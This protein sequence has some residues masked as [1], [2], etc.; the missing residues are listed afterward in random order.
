MPPLATRT[1][2]DGPLLVL[3]HGFTQTS[4][5]WGPF[6]T[7]LGR[8]RT[9]MAVDL[10]GHGRSAH[11]SADLEQTADLVLETVGDRHFDLLG[12]SLG[13]RVAVTTA[14]AAPTRVARLVLIGATAGIEDPAAAAERRARDQSLAD[15]IVAESNVPAFLERWLD[16]DLFADLSAEDAQRP[17]RLTNTAAGLADSLRRAG[18]G[19]QVSAW[20]RL[21]E[22]TM[23]TLVLAGHADQKFAD[24]GRKMVD[25]LPEGQLV[26]IPG[27]GHA[28]HL[29]QPAVTAGII[30]SWLG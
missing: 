6:G 10:P 2:G 19:T 12:Y 3:L 27:A 1:W 24:L 25:A 15:Q 17:A 26:L 30:D 21:G 8:S 20:G 28:C 9:I 16:Q 23:P 4:D 18:S 7:I 29:I 5:A 13:R 11:V 14:L 22:L